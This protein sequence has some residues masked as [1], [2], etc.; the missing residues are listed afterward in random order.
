M[1]QIPTPRRSCFRTTHRRSSVLALALAIAVAGCARDGEPATRADAVREPIACLDG[2]VIAMDDVRPNVAF[3]VYQREVD[4]Y[5]LLKGEAEGLIE[6][7]L[8]AREAERRGISVDELLR[9][10]VDAPS[11]PAT[12]AD[13]DAYLAEHPEAAAGGAEVRPRIQ[14][15]LSETRKIERRLRLLRQ[16]RSQAR[17]EFLLQP[18]AQP[19]VRLSVAGAPAR[20]PADAAVTLVHF[21]T[22]SSPLSARSVGYLERLFE[23]FPDRLRWVHRTFLDDH[24]EVGLLAAE[25][26][27]A[28]HEAGRFWD[29][30]DRLFTL[31]GRLS[32]DDVVRVAGEMGMDSAR[33][34]AAQTDTRYLARV[35]QDI[36]AGVKAGVKREPVVFVNGRYFSGTFPYDELHQLVVEELEA[37]ARETT[38]R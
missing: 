6:E 28:A 25:M 34:A 2:E 22:F 20:G 29:F 31:G 26:A 19:R 33:R 4:I 32:A 8:L 35:K 14:H 38:A 24:D 36:D 12:D 37:V 17:I 3:Q 11:A 16:L 5:S 23:E 10:E 27:V 1:R 21:S 18:P 13:V 9:R 7:R 15:Y 30:H